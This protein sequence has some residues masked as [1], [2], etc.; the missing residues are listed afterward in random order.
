MRT[1]IVTTDKGTK[2]FDA[3]YVMATRGVDNLFARIMD[4]RLLSQVA[5]DFEGIKMLKVDD[6]DFSLYNELTKV[7]RASRSE[8]SLVLRRTL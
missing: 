7:N 2:S 1:L 5:A 6:D 4:K 3:V 8:V